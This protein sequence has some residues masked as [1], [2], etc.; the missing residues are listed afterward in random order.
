MTLGPVALQL[1][2]VWFIVYINEN[3]NNNNNDN[4]NKYFF[5]KKI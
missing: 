2:W 1:G 5:L 4:N 3:N